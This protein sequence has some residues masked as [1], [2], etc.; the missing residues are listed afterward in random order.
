VR[1]GIGAWIKGMEQAAQNFQ[2]IGDLCEKALKI[3]G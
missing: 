2:E 1:E 3:W